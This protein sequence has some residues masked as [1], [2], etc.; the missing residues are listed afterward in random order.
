MAHRADDDSHDNSIRDRTNEIVSCAHGILM[1]NGLVMVM[2][3]W[4]PVTTCFAFNYHN[5]DRVNSDNDNYKVNFHSNETA[6]MCAIVNIRAR[7]SFVAMERSPILLINI[8][9]VFIVLKKITNCE[10]MK[11]NQIQMTMEHSEKYYEWMRKNR[12]NRRWRTK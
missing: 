12:I 10:W 2:V 9:I 3:R 7:R 6:W 4:M 8:P 1:W 5:G 11:R